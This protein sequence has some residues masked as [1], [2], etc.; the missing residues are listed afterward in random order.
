[1]RPWAYDS[2]MDSGVEKDAPQDTGE[3]CQSCSEVRHFTVRGSWDHYFDE[4]G[5][6]FRWI[7]RSCT[8]CFEP[9]M[10]REQ[11]EHAG[12]M[13]GE[14]FVDESCWDGGVVLY[15][16]P[17]R[18]SDHV[19][20]LI[21]R[22]YDEAQRCMSVSAYVA[23]AMMFRRGL[24]QVCIDHGVPDSGRTFSLT[25][26]LKKLQDLGKLPEDLL[27]WANSIKLVGDDGAHSREVSREDVSDADKLFEALCDYLYSYRRQYEAFTER[28]SGK[29]DVEA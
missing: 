7:V 24:E 12:F 8:V 18:I 21:R 15:P 26:K 23:A 1:M 4:T 27:D 2:A 10:V 5:E 22:D 14:R 17:R 19:P 11:Y 13:V 16:E 28:R 9:R 3:F 6:A 20:E 29:G 25:G